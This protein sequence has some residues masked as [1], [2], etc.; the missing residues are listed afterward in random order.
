M[1]K[2]LNAEGATLNAER[3][4]LLMKKVWTIIRGI[5]LQKGER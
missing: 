5:R 3:E 4:A 2:T 1:A